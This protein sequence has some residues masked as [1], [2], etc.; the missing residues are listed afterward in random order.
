VRRPGQKQ[1]RFVYLLLAIL[2][3]GIAYYAGNRYHSPEPARISGILLR[4]AT[5]VPGFELKDQN[6]EPFS[7]QQLLGHWSLLVLDP[8][9]GIDSA[10]L[11]RLVQV[12]N[13]LA[14]DPD[15]QKQ[16]RFV[17]LPSSHPQIENPLPPR[18][19]AREEAIANGDQFQPSIPTSP[20]PQRGEVSA[21]AQPEQELSRF[22]PGPHLPGDGF[23][24]L[25]GELDGISDV[26][27]RFGV[28]TD[29]DG[30]TLYLID[31]E[32]NIQALFTG[33]QDAATIAGDFNTLITHQ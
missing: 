1:R 31:P 20:F 21:Q 18:G 4:H 6:G 15:I 25:H 14:I 3:F 5:P 27:E 33:T 28:E 2:T 22:N 13:R 24:A 26:F 30:F 16:T 19:S 12:H 29:S 10:A 8:K 9:P 23:V 11:R 32:N 17:Y 7:E